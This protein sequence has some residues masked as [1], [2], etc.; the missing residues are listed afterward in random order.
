M[1]GG[2]TPPSAAQIQANSHHEVPGTR[3]GLYAAASE[4]LSAVVVADRA[5]TAQGERGGAAGSDGTPGEDGVPLTAVN[6]D[7]Y[8]RRKYPRMML[9][10][11]EDVRSGSEDKASRVATPSAGERLPLAPSDKEST[12]TTGREEDRRVDSPGPGVA[13]SQ[14]MVGGA[15]SGNSDP[16]A[17]GPALLRTRRQRLAPVEITECVPPPAAGRVQG[18]DARRAD[19]WLEGG[20]WQQARGQRTSTVSDRS[21]RVE[22]QNRFQ[23]LTVE[24]GGPT[25]EPDMSR[26]DRE[27]ATLHTRTGA[28]AH[29]RRTPA[30]T[31]TGSR[32]R[33]PTLAD[34]MPAHGPLLRSGQQRRRGLT[35]AGAEGILSERIEKWSERGLGEEGEPGCVARGASVGSRGKACAGQ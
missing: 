34:Y 5:E 24:E 31:S 7:E 10:D 8:M 18:G 17:V 19:G 35:L 23:V 22:T 4:G 11:R 12:H 9:H 15:C 26:T 27:P 6:L 21:W 20:E 33:L 30:R 32:R 14:D 25:E 2:A 1:C 13:W 28:K 16:L 29:S 3:T